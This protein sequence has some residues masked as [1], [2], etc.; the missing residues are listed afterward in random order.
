MN[1]SIDTDTKVFF[2]TEAEILIQMEITKFHC[3]LLFT[4]VNNS[5]K[6]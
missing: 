2:W 4:K 5:I 3:K 1:L 6:F